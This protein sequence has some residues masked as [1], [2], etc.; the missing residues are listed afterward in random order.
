MVSFD[1]LG[2]V[3]LSRG[4]ASELFSH[5]PFGSRC[6][7][8]LDASEAFGTQFLRASKALRKPLTTSGWT[9]P[10]ILSEQGR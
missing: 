4:I 6:G 3:F 10:E 8:I 7:I 2:R 9:R 5:L 1:V